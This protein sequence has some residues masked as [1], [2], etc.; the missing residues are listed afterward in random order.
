M[1]KHT[2]TITHAGLLADHGVMDAVQAERTM[3]GARRLLSAS[4]Y[5]YTQGRVPVRL[6][7]R[8]SYFQIVEFAPEHGSLTRELLIGIA[9]SGIYDIAKVYF[10]E[11]FL[12]AVALSAV[13]LMSVEKERWIEL[14]KRI[15]DLRREDQPTR[16]EPVLPM[17]SFDRPMYEEEAPRVD[18]QQ[19]GAR[20]TSKRTIERDLVDET[21]KAIED[22]IHPTEQGGALRVEIRLDGDLLIKI[23]VARSALPSARAD[24]EQQIAVAVERMRVLRT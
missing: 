23:E 4:A 19:A 7:A 18:T 5:Y 14:G 9:G 1:Q 6:H 8:N 24:L 2:L 15:R 16:I 12:T 21:S 3:R 13:G 17:P 20:R 22:L 10:P 11:V